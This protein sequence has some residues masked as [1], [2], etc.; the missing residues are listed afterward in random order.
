MIS[1]QRRKIDIQETVTKLNIMKI[2]LLQF[3]RKKNCLLIPTS[4]FQRLLLLNMSWHLSN[5]FQFI[6][7]FWSLCINICLLLYL[8]LAANQEA[9]KKCKAVTTTKSL[10]IITTIQSCRRF[11]SYWNIHFTATVSNQQRY[12]SSFCLFCV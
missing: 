8:P 11:S 6:E 5:A 7:V 9:H 4:N 12:H 10:W 2:I 1:L 3:F